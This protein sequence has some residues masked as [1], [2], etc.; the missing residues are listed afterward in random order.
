MLQHR[1]TSFN[2]PCKSALLL[3]IVAPHNP[4]L[5][6]CLT[7][8]QQFHLGWAGM[9]IE[10]MLREVCGSTA[11]PPCL[12][13]H[14]LLGDLVDQIALPTTKPGGP[15]CSFWPLSNTAVGYSRTSMELVQSLCGC[16]TRWPWRCWVNGWTLILE[17]FST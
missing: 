15:L 7:G 8:F 17:G 10:R 3:A 11:M 16:G 6:L 12:R 4:D 9:G 1:G 5:W 2:F 14:L 13:C